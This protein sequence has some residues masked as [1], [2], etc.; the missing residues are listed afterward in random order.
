MKHDPYRDPNMNIEDHKV[1]QLA[2]CPWAAATN[3]RPSPWPT[4]ATRLPCWL[5]KRPGQNNLQSTKY[6][7]TPHLW[8]QTILQINYLFPYWCGWCSY[9]H[10]LDLMIFEIMKYWSKMYCTQYETPVSVNTGF[11]ISLP[12]SPPPPRWVKVPTKRKI[13]MLFAGITCLF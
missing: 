1:G 7:K 5:M 3:L 2:T 9:R 13:L 4:Q 10:L 6:Y 12:W 11:S 8:K